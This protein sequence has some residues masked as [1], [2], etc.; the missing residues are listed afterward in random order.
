MYI[1]EY[2]RQAI[3]KIDEDLKKPGLTAA[4]RKALLW[5]KQLLKEDLEGPDFDMGRAEEFSW[6]GRARRAGWIIEPGF[7]H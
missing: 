4:E 3:E 7:G 2:I 1:S 5:A 6:A